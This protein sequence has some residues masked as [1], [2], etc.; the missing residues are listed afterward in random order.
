VK[1]HI[2]TETNYC[3]TMYENHPVDGRYRCTAAGRYMDTDGRV[4]CER[5]ATGRVVTKLT[6]VPKLIDLVDRLV[7]LKAP[8]MTD[9]LRT[10]LRALVSRATK[11]SP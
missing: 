11:V 4:I 2:L 1:K 5:C 3:A 9:D 7:D 10:Q 6:D 8:Q